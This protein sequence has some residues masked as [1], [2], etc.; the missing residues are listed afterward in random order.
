[1][2]DTQARIQLPKEVSQRMSHLSCA[3]EGWERRSFQFSNASHSPPFLRIF[4]GFPIL[5]NPEQTTITPLFF[6]FLVGGG[7]S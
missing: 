2:R 4:K 7:V 1:M 5:S 3:K 6:F